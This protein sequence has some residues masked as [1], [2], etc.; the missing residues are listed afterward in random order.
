VSTGALVDEAVAAGAL[1]PAECQHAKHRQV[2]RA[3]CGDDRR[4]GPVAA[5]AHKLSPEEREAVLVAANS[6]EFRDKA[7]GKCESGHRAGRRVRTRSSTSRSSVR[8]SE[9]FDGGKDI[10]VEQ[11]ARG[12][13]LRCLLVPHSVMR[14]CAAEAARLAHS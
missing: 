13:R 5:P 10:F 1:R 3:R 2:A 4:K 7:R 6:V 12:E 14:L 11:A 8:V 9:N